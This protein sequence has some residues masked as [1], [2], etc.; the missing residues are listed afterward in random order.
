MKTTRE[1][2]LLCATTFLIC[3]CSGGG[4]GGGGSAP[5][6][7]P[8]TEF[9]M[10]DVKAPANAGVEGGF[11]YTTMQTVTVD[12]D[13]PYPN[14]LVSLYVKRP[15]QSLYDAS[16]NAATSI[17]LTAEPLAQGRTSATGVG[18]LYRYHERITLPTATSTIYV[19]PMMGVKPSSIDVPI[20]NGT[21]TY[22]FTVGGAL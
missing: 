3:S 7:P 13:L 16:G 18:G 6:P 12:I 8:V 19:E 17:D 5:T 14:G 20:T 21:A 4:G 2:L 15:A 11:N 10:A 22:T 1:I 9:K